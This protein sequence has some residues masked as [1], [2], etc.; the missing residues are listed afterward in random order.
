MIEIIRRAMIA[1]LFETINNIQIVEEQTYFDHI[2]NEL[3]SIYSKVEIY[4]FEAIKEILST[5]KI[6]Y[7]ITML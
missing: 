7:I 6:K 4:S 1:M 5:E 3:H 2:V